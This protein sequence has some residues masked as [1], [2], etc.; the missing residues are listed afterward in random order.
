MSIHGLFDCVVRVYRSSDED[1]QG[2]FGDV[3]LIPTFV[4]QNRA[5]IQLYRTRQRDEGA[6][7]RPDGTAWLYIEKKSLIKDNDIIRVIAGPN[8]ET[9]WSAS[10]VFLPS[11][12]RHREALLKPYI[13]PKP[14][15]NEDG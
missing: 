13:G 10:G 3:D 12:A 5:T 15:V 11:R 4:C 6:G 1:S 8:V 7:D 14:T 9:Y 2:E